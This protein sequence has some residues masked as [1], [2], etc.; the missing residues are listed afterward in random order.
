MYF[1]YKAENVGGKG[2]NVLQNSDLGFLYNLT[3]DKTISNMMDIMK[4][5]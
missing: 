3:S 5:N 2:H 4:F 1:R